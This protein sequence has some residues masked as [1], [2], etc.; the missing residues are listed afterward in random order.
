[1]SASESVNNSGLAGAGGGRRK[2]L[3]KLSSSPSIIPPCA[4][5]KNGEAD[6]KN[7]IKSRCTIFTRSV[8]LIVLCFVCQTIAGGIGKY[9]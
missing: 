9:W 4:D 5:T 8:V 2:E 3:E 6:R 7:A 1:M